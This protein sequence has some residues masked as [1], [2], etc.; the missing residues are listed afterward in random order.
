MAL[1]N[2]HSVRECPGQHPEVRMEAIC[3]L[4]SVL[5]RAVQPSPPDYIIT[6][7]LEDPGGKA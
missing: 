2:S 3:G 5:R 7:T 4:F 1:E 6:V